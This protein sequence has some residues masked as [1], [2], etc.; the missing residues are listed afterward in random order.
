MALT[1]A[2]D[3][4]RS[5]I[6][7]AR[8]AKAEK[9]FPRPVEGLLRPAVRGT[10]KRYN[11][12]VR[13]GRGFTLEE[14]K[15]AGI[16]A[17]YAQTIGI[18][19]DHRRRNKSLETMQANVNRLKTYMS[20]L[21]LFPRNAKAPKAGD[22]TANEVA[23][24]EQL[25]GKILP[26]AKEKFA[27]EFAPVTDELKAASAYGKLRLEM[28]NKRQVGPRFKKAQEEAAKEAEKKKLN[29]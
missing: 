26:L 24:A 11:M 13:L 3:A 29:K 1:R 15:E 18:A 14:L 7:A 17:K 28:M 10:S 9:V 8:A 2:R 22:A 5:S 12:K 20:K 21:V 23:T 4:T 19:V 6:R 16:G 27:V 25:E